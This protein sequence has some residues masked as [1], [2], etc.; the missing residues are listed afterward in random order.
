VAIEKTEQLKM[1]LKNVIKLPQIVQSYIDYKNDDEITQSSFINSTALFLRNNNNDGRDYMHE[2][3]YIRHLLMVLDCWDDIKRQ[4]DNLYSESEPEEETCDHRYRLTAAGA[5]FPCRV[6]FNS[7]RRRR[8]Q[9]RLRLIK[10]RQQ[11]RF[12][13]VSRRHLRSSARL[14]NL[15]YLNNCI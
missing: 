7:S 8:Q 6:R 3:Y 5:C 4:M 10:H 12:P 14:C 13:R 15:N 9:R 1:T 2:F 11:Q